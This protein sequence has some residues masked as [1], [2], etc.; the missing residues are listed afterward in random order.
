MTD[1]TA[2]IC[3]VDGHRISYHTQ[4]QGETILFVHGITTYSFI[5]RDLIPYFSNDY[6]VVSLDLLGC[7]HSDKPLDVPYSIKHHVELLNR[8]IDRLGIE[9]VHYVGHDVGGGIG[10]RLAVKYPERLHDLTLINTVAYDFWPVQPIVAM[11]TPIIRQMAMASLDYG[12]LRYIIRKGFHNKQKITPEVMDA[13]WMP[14]R[15]KSGRKGFLHF[16]QC[17]NNRHLTEIEDQLHRL[18]LPVLVIRGEADLYLSAAI[19]E[20]L[21]ANIPHARLVKIP[22]AGHFAQIDEPEGVAH[23]VK[24]FLSSN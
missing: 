12:A 9:K 1:E 15:S 14:M 11:R 8:F 20:K 22:D 10:Q 2:A 18:D 13:F 17:L 7:G 3:D 5:W 21:V 23:A 16:A 6:R 4:G 24:Q 19:A